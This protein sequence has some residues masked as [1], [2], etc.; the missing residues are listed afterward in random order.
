MRKPEAGMTN[1]QWSTDSPTPTRRDLIAGMSMVIGSLAVRSASAGAATAPKEIS[2]SAESIHQE[3]ILKAEPA[4]VYGALTDAVKFQQ[5][6]LLS[7]AVKS[8]MVQ[9]TTPAEISAA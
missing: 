6:V 3:V 9:T 4:R 7:A 2:H 8:G 5:V 1:E